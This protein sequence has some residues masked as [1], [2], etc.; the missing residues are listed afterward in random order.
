MVITID[1]PQA[2][3]ALGVVAAAVVTQAVALIVLL[4]LRVVGQPNSAKM[5]DHSAGLKS[6]PYWLFWVVS[7]FMQWSR[8]FQQLKPAPLR[9]AE[10]AVAYLQSQV[11]FA[12]VNLGIPEALKDGPKTAD[13]LAAAAGRNTNPDWLCRVLKLAAEVGLVRS[14]RHRGLWDKLTGICVGICGVLCRGDGPCMWMCCESR[15][16]LG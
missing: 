8:H 1:T 4:G 3:V 16:L 6:L 9:V 11:L 10:V 15:R 12:I 5:R 7:K 13:Q 2:W 14:M